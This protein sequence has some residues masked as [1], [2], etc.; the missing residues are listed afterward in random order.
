MEIIYKIVCNITG[1]T[2]IGSTTKSIEQCMYNIASKS[3]IDRNN[4]TVINYCPCGGQWKT[5]DNMNKHFKTQRHKT[6]IEFLNK[7]NDGLSLI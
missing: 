6:Y 7:N 3:I 5:N 4:Y 1:E 2:Y